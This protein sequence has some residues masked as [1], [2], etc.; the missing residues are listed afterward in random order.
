MPK[1]NTFAL[2]RLR[3]VAIICVVGSEL[4]LKNRRVRMVMRPSDRIEQT[5]VAQR[6]PEG[7]QRH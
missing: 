5:G 1:V 3:D 4:N 2:P 7:V 6:H